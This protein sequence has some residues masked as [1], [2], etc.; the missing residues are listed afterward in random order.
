MM[1]NPFRKSVLVKILLAVLTFLVCVPPSSAIYGTGR[2]CRRR[3]AVVVSSSEK[4]AQK[5]A[6][7][8]A[9]PK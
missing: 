2:R 9:T 8:A 1:Q 6:A 5:Q 3:T 7:A 4:N